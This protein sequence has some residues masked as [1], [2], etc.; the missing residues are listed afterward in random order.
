MARRAYNGGAVIGFR[1]GLIALIGLFG[2]NLELLF[3][4]AEGLSLLEGVKGDV[5]AI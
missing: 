3:G 5:R 2:I 1:G 4:S